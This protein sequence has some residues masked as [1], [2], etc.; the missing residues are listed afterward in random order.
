MSSKDD[1]SGLPWPEGY[2]LIVRDE[3]DSTMAEA[4]RL[5]PTITRPTWIMAHRQ[6]AA[7]G[8]QGK[9]WEMPPGNLA[10]TLIYRPD[11]TLAEA[12]GRSFMA[13]VAL[14]EAL[15]LSV[16]RTRLA[17]KWPNDVLLDGGKVAGILLESAARDRFV[18][19]LAVGVGVN[20]AAAPVLADA[21]FAPI[22]VASTGAKVAPRA[23]LTALADCFAT[24]EEKL[25]AFGFP[26]IREDWLRHAAK[27]GE[28]ITVRIGGTTLRGIFDTVDP[29]GNLILL[30]GA[31][32]KIIA[33][34]DVHF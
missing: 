25:A 16:D 21:P 9:A 5:L 33:A 13:A 15:A 17:L 27:V 8:R 6:T 31:G 23:F 3:V 22:S 7:R 30:T 18:D 24:Q 2:D 28:E 20:L 11:A 12:A 34:A 10:A 4:Q 29:A 14:F 19:W 32:P 1:P 26:R